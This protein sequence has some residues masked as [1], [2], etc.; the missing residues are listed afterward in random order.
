[1]NRRLRA[2]SVLFSLCAA[3][4]A[5][6]AEPITTAPIVVTATRTA[7]TADQTLSSVTVITR[8]DIRR[9]GAVTLPQLLRQV[10]GLNVAGN[11][12]FGKLTSVFLRGTNSNDVLVMIDG[13]R[14]GSVTTGGVSWEL[15]P[16]SQIQRIEI[17]RGPHSSL[18]GS[19]AVGGVIQIFTRRGRGPLHADA[20]AG[21]GSEETYRAFGGVSGAL[22]RGWL[23]LR[24]GGLGTEGINVSRPVLGFN[25]PDA[26]GYHNDSFSAGAGYDWA[27]GTAVRINALRAT[28]TTRYDNFPPS[29]FS[30]PPNADRFLQE[31]V[32]GVVRLQPTDA[33]TVHLRA[34]RSLDD[35]TSFR[36]GSSA[37]PTRFDSERISAGWQNDVAVGSHQLVT[38]GVDYLD[39]RVESTTRYDRTSRYDVGAYAQYQ[40]RVALVDLLGAVRLDHDEQFGNH[41]TGNVALGY[42]L[43]KALRL[44][45]S[46]GTAFRAPTFNDLYFPGYSN[47]NLQ[48]E[49]S[50]TVE[51]G[52]RGRHAWGHWHVDAYRT[53]IRDLIQ[54]DARFIPQNIGRASIRGLEAGLTTRVLGWRLDLG[55]DFM[56][57][58]DEVSG[59]TLTRR[60]ERSFKLALDRGFGRAH[61]HAEWIAEGRR[62]DQFFDPTTF[63]SER[64]RLAGYGTLGLDLRYDLTPHWTLNAALNNAFD[65]R[66]E[67]VFGYNQLG[68][69]VFVSV[70]YSGIPWGGST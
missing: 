45:A 30:T 23:S 40:L 68:R 70:R 67:T 7:E 9:S 53:G 56:R 42:R 12:P 58:H 8:A 31:V 59:L 41:T 21:Y 32:G 24:G 16:L 4:A 26:D 34:G 60:P 2:V 35:R 19:S 36:E 69:T 37:A 27:N 20:S 54:L 55:V 50:D 11:G 46:Y 3:G 1:V 38:A 49:T 65:R 66:Y 64:V 18:Y 43:T 10:N 5:R 52:V 14:V 48:P 44:T 17:V 61:L 28:G 51:V 47:P 39:D 22:G 57:P 33:W 25:E 15:L 63:Q 6:A 29:S 13:V 62:F